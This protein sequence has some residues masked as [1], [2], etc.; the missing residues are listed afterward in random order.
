MEALAIALSQRPR[1]APLLTMIAALIPPVG[2]LRKY[3]NILKVATDIIAQRPI[4]RGN[5]ATVRLAPI[6]VCN[7]RCLFCEVHKDNLLYPDRKHNVVAL[8]HIRNYDAFLGTASRISFY[9]GSAEPLLNRHFGDIVAYLKSRYGTELMVNTNGSCLNE[10]LSDIFIKYG[11][12]YILLSYHAGTEATYRQLMTGDISR[13]D[14]KLM[15][16]ADRKAM[17]NRQNPIIDLNFALHKLNAG[18]YRAIMEKAKRFNVLTVHVNR[19]YGGRNKLQDQHVSFEFDTENGNRTLDEIYRFARQEGIRLWPDHP[20]YW[21]TTEPQ[22]NWNSGKIN[23]DLRC[24]APWT[25]LQLDPV[26]DEDDCHYASVCNRI[27]LF[28]IRYEIAHFRT[29]QA[30][31][32]LWNHPLLRYLRE[33]VNADVPNPICKYCKNYDRELLRN[34]DA[35]KYASVRDRAVEDFFHESRARGPYPEIPGVEVLTTNPDAD[36]R[37]RDKLTAAGLFA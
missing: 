25:S 14:V 33:T 34:V 17:L 18:E 12:D 30:F 8:D 5:P 37:F 27:Q 29:K 1:L 20:Q 22:V 28:R 3:G 4:C 32:Q 26:L 16:L 23:H 11:F 2:K 31:K 7:Y 15:Y 19:Y 13:V 6:S 24:Y 21:E 35:R 10:G 9:G 36:D